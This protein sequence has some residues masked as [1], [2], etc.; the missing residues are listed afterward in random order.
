IELN[1]RSSFNRS[2]QLEGLKTLLNPWGN[3][4]SLKLSKQWGTSLNQWSNG[5]LKRSMDKT[6]LKLKRGRPKTHKLTYAFR[7][8]KGVHDYVGRQAADLGISMSAFIENAIY[9]YV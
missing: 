3:G 9:Q 4:V 5:G 2:G 6:R 8:S 7:M 1:G